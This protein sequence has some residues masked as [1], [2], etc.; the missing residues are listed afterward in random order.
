M[1]INHLRYLSNFTNETSYYQIRT[2]LTLVVRIVLSSDAHNR[3]FG[4]ILILNSIKQG[5]RVQRVPD[6]FLFHGQAIKSLLL[7][8]EQH[9]SYPCAYLRPFG[10]PLIFFFQGIGISIKYEPT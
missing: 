9:I 3:K 1:A 7:L 5:L 10:I 6:I 2:L 8:P 4:E